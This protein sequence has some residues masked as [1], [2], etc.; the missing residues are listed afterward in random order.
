MDIIRIPLHRLAHALIFV[1]LCALR[2]PAAERKSELLLADGT[3]YSIAERS[4]RSVHLPEGWSIL[5]AS[6]SPDSQWLAFVVTA[7]TIPK[8]KVDP[9]APKT[10]P[11]PL[12][13]IN[14]AMTLWSASTR[15][16]VFNRQ[17][18]MIARSTVLKAPMKPEDAILWLT[19]TTPQ[20][21]LK[22][23]P[24]MDQSRCPQ[25]LV[26]AH[27]KNVRFVREEGRC[28]TPPQESDFYRLLR[29]NER[30]HKDAVLWEYRVAVDT[31]T[32]SDRYSC[33]SGRDTQFL[34]TAERQ[35]L[36]W[37]GDLYELSETDDGMD[38]E[39]ITQLLPQYS[40][41]FGIAV[42]ETHLHPLDT[43][44]HVSF[45]PVTPS[46]SIPHGE[47]PPVYAQNFSPSRSFNVSVEVGPYQKSILV[48]AGYQVG[49]VDLGSFRDRSYTPVLISATWTSFHH[50]VEPLFCK[51]PYT[52]APHTN[53]IA[54]SITENEK[55]EL[56]CHISTQ[57][58]LSPRQN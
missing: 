23:S 53:G 17:T 49:P 51:E 12:G 10:K 4:Y 32:C 46:L 2:L 55:G 56:Q 3:L 44:T 54:V 6:Y 43:A 41:P 13:P 29:P 48:P 31:A 30:S 58:N 9:T 1:A 33:Y 28:S 19:N 47:N 7:A 37:D 14:K 50:L 15:L 39:L 45:N 22:P 21:G 52:I 36:A 20:L 40:H 57:E 5:S 16:V 24:V 26:Q 11:P 38:V 8:L 25:T 42:G 34:E 35:F 27:G 18:G